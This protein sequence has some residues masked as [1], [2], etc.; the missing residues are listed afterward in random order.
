MVDTDFL[1]D[2]YP[3]VSLLFRI[4]AGYKVIYLKGIEHSMIPLL[5]Q[6]AKIVL[7][8]GLPGPERISSEGILMGAIPLLSDRWAG[9]SDYDFPVSRKI[10][11]VDH[12]N[13]T[14]VYE[15]LQYIA[16][17]YENELSQSLHNSIFF[18]YILS[19]FRRSHNTADVILG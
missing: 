9:S 8:L 7:D 17:N 1:S 16:D 14:A 15:K 19:L 18:S 3:E 2:Y 12:L 5:L 6:R 10:N 4:P 13:E 11:K